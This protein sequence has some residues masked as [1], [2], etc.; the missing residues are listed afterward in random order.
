MTFSRKHFSVFIVCAA[1]VLSALAQQPLAPIPADAR[2]KQA[3]LPVE[4]R[5]RDLLSR[6]TVE[7]K[8]RQLDMYRGVSPSIGDDAK[9]AADGTH[10]DAL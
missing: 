7:E 10:Y 1:A 4:D 5:V 9:Q 6:M 3:T 8:A 2:Y